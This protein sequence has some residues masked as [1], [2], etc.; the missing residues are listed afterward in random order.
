MNMVHGNDW[1]K[2]FNNQLSPM[3]FI[4]QISYLIHLRL[5][6]HF[7]LPLPSLSSDMLPAPPVPCCSVCT[8]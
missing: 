7:S 1:L 8:S 6:V 5:Q 2:R 4:M 3:P